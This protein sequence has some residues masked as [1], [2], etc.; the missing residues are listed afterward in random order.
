VRV[1]ISQKTLSNKN[2]NL[3]GTGFAPPLF[4]ISK[5]F[6]FASPAKS[7]ANAA[8]SMKS[9]AIIQNLNFL[10]TKT[11]ATTTYCALTT[12]KSK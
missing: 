8:W 9:P 3:T 10:F 12:C 7:A 5:K 4:K 6:K 2:L 1:L 11:Q